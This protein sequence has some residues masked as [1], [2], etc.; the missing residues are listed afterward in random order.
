MLVA[1]VC[2]C[3]KRD[4]CWG[5]D[6]KSSSCKS[7]ARRQIVSLC[8]PLSPAISISSNTYL[9]LPLLPLSHLFNPILQPALGTQQK[10]VVALD[11]GGA[12]LPD[13][14]LGIVTLWVTPG[15]CLTQIRGVREAGL[16]GGGQGGGGGG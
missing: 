8:L 15:A 2:V 9:L 5:K 14:N 3:E 16:R 10:V 12:T 1:V 11:R 7:A 4:P 6:E 13:L